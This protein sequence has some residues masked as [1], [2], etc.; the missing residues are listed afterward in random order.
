M[1]IRKK[2]SCK[3]RKI[4]VYKKI[5]K[6]QHSNVDTAKSLTIIVGEQ[7]NKKFLG[8]YRQRKAKTKGFM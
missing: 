6:N 8:R 4:K 2:N 5:S 7:G 3:P 1:I